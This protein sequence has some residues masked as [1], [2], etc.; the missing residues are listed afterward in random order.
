MKVLTVG[1]LRKVLDQLRDSDL[2][3]IECD[4]DY[5]SGLV[6]AHNTM[7]GTAIKLAP[8]TWQ[9]PNE[10]EFGRK[11]PAGPRTYH[12]PG[13]W[14]LDA[15]ADEELPAAVLERRPC[16]VLTATHDRH[17]LDLEEKKA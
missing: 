13:F 11:R 17:P 16:L 3:Y 7:L 9:D 12:S 15:A 10:D 5:Y 14:R 2:V 4:D 1:D 8:F 6:C